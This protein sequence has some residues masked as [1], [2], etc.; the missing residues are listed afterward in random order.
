MG[1][2]LCLSWVTEISSP[3][4]L[5]THLIKTLIINFSRVTCL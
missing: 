1:Y 4:L 5:E 3:I 2:F